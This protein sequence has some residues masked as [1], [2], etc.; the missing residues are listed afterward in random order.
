[1]LFVCLFGDSVVS[2]KAWLKLRDDFLN[3]QKQEIVELKKK[4]AELTQKLEELRVSHLKAKNAN[5]KTDDI[6]RGCVIKLT[7]HATNEAEY[8]LFK[9]TRQQFKE[10]KLAA[11][12][13]LSHVAYVDIEKSLNRI[14]IRCHTPEAAKT[15]LESAQFLP[16]LSEPKRLLVGKEEDEY[17]ER[18]IANRSKKLEKKDRKHHNKTETSDPSNTTATKAAAAD[19]TCKPK[20]NVPATRTT[21]N[22]HRIKAE[23]TTGSLAMPTKTASRIT[24]DDEDEHDDTNHKIISE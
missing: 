14:L 1:M 8:A 11:G 2:K 19:L 4:L 5:V 23:K 20:Q 22:N 12:D 24:F 9:L 17:F 13:L 3:K 18:I 21:I 6:V 16:E 10:Q 7:I 15:L